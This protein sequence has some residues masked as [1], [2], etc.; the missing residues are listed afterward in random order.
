MGFHVCVVDQVTGEIVNQSAVIN[1]L[2][3]AK[4]LEAAMVLKVNLE[5]FYVRIDAIQSYA[6]GK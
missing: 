1:N 3:K 4:K 6:G 5:K 2:P